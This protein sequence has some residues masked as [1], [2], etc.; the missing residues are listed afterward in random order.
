MFDVR[1]CGWR[2]TLLDRSQHCT[3]TKNKECLPFAEMSGTQML[4]INFAKGSTNTLKA[5]IQHIIQ[6]KSFSKRFFLSD[7]AG[8]SCMNNLE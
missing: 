4:L 1:I 2:E 7:F 3:S 5:G 8:L 6:C